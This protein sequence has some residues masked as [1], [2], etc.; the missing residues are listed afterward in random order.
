MAWSLISRLLPYLLAVSVVFAIGGIGYRIGVDSTD[1]KWQARSNAALAAAMAQAAQ[2]QAEVR[3]EEQ[4]R[5]AAI[6]EVMTNA[7]EQINQAEADAVAAV[8]AADS[9]RDAADR[10][11]R[12]LADTE[13]SFSACTTAAS[14]AAA[15]NARVLADVFKRADERAGHLAQVADQARARGL[16]CE[17]SYDGVRGEAR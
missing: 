8:S 1:A 12:E 3:E 5:Q 7:Q 10:L 9:L 16:A 15:R 11:A 4:R 13:A 14:E 6:D 17:A 2:A